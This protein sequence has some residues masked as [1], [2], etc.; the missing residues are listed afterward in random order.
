MQYP[1]WGHKNLHGLKVFKLQYSYK[2]HKT[3]TK[4]SSSNVIP[5]LGLQKHVWIDGIPTAIPT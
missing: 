1:Y 3:H 5:A 2:V 4:K